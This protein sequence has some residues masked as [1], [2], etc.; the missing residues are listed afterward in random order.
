M[1]NII[2]IASGWGAKYGGINSFNYDL[3]LALPACLDEENNRIIC[4]TTGDMIT[5]EDYKYAENKNLILINVAKP[6]FNVDIIVEKVNSVLIDGISWWIGHDIK[7]GFLAADCAHKTNSKCAIIHHMNYSAYYTY[8]TDDATKT[9]QKQNDQKK[10]FEKADVIFSVGPKLTKSA[11]DILNEI[12]KLPTAIQLIPGL[13]DIEPI[14]EVMTQFS[15]ITFGR[16][17]INKRDI[18]KQSKLAVAAFAD[19]CN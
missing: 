12:G 18:V 8:I 7:T 10:L 9:D 4:V 3:C 2:F 13:A 11:N 6:D 15:A 5:R 19:A 17:N 1:A 14:N 16:I